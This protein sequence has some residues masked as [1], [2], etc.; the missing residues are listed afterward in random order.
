MRRA[1][2]GFT[3]IELMIVVAIMGI[4]AAI[5]IPSY[6]AYIR[7]TK[8]IEA[9]ENLGALYRLSASYY[10][11]TYPLDRSSTAMGYSHCV[12]ESDGPVP[13]PPSPASTVV[14]WGAQPSF[15]A[16]G[17]SVSAP[18]RY[19]YQIVSPG[20]CSHDPLSALY[21]FRALGDLDG[22]G[23]TSLFEV[24]SGVN[25]SNV[26]VRSPGTYIRNADE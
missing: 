24:S 25:A 5:A 2:R 8:T 3:L 19:S 16:L 11:R 6:L 22:N 21:S 23:V 13:A 12:V 18:T 26:P 9:T 17:F 4:L 7:R 10:V 15:A 20:G 1:E 14:D